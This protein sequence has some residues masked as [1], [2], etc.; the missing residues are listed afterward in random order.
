MKR[1]ILIVLVAA[2]LGAGWWYV[3]SRPD[4]LMPIEDAAERVTDTMKEAAGVVSAPPPLLK[5]EDAPNARLTVDG[6]FAETNRHRAENGV[7]ALKHDATLDAAAQAKLKDMFDRQYFAHESPT[8]EGPADVI[9]AAGYDYVMVGEN[10]ALGNFADDRELVQAW[11]DSPGHRANILEPKFTEIGIAVGRGMYAGRMTW[12]AVQEFGKPSSD[13]P[14]VSS[15]LQAKIAADKDALAGLQARADALKAEIE[16]SRKPR[17]R[18]ERDA[19]NAKV[20]EYN[21]L[22]RE[23]NALIGQIQGEI[24]VYN[25]QVQAFNACAGS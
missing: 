17:T 8:G 25:G 24:T 16:A 14:A 1:I 18:E 9:S 6:V 20:D 11:M 2:G 13:C 10:L 4:L 5:E 3:S 22:V 15:S 19:Y 7:P 23:I 12:I 21:A